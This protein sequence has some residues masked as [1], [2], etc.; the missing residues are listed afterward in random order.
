MICKF[1]QE[2]VRGNPCQSSAQA[3]NCVNNRDDD[4]PEDHMQYESVYEK[5]K[6]EKVNDT[7]KK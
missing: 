3:A 1:C 6:S 4:W 2:N 7:E 5:E